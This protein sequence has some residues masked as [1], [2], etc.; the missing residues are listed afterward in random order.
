MKHL[1][2]LYFISLIFSHPAMANDDSEIQAQ[3]IK[4]YCLPPIEKNIPPTDFALSLGLTEMSPDE[5]P[6]Y[7]ASGARIF[8]VPDSKNIILIAETGTKTICSLA[9]LKTNAALL[10]QKL[11]KT[12]PPGSPFKL[13]KEKRIETLSLT[14]KTYQADMSGPVTILI[15]VSDTARE[16]GIQAL[17]TIARHK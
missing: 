17:F 9:I 10:W 2:I 4:K 3:A 6:A 13:Q 11:D 14:R 8:A 16:S 5:A 12:F 7:A 1:I 15:S